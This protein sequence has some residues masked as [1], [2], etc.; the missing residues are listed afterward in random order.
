MDTAAAIRMGLHDIRQGGSGTGAE[1]AAGDDFREGAA[2]RREV[3][4]VHGERRALSARPGVRVEAGRALTA[5][6]PQ[7][8]GRFASAAP[9]SAS[10]RDRGDLRKGNGGHPQGYGGGSLVWPGERGLHRRPTRADAVSLPYP[11]PYGLRVQGAAEV[12]L[13]RNGRVFEKR[14]EPG[15]ANANRGRESAFS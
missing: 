14:F 5:D 1:G 6:V 11:A 3:Q 12:R 10:V 2:G 8:D 15:A 7:P 4:P 13:R 9:A